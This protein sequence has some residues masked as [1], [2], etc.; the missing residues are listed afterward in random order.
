MGFNYKMW[1][2]HE[3]KC[4]LAKKLISILLQFEG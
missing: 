1:K 2:E 3:E 4:P